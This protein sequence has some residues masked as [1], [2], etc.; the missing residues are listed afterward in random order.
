M[1]QSPETVKLVE[2]A[3]TLEDTYDDFILSMSFSP[4]RNGVEK[5]LWTYIE[6]NRP[7]RSDEI[8][9]QQMILTGKYKGDLTAKELVAAILEGRF[10]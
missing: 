9:A 10:N 7:T 4:Q 5:E 6:E 8:V 2:Y 1:E 3:R